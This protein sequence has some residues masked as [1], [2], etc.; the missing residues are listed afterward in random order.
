MA[1]MDRDEA[2]RRLREVVPR[3]DTTPFVLRHPAVEQ[4]L[5]AG[6]LGA[7]ITRLCADLGLNFPEPIPTPSHFAELDEITPTEA[8]SIADFL[9]AH[10]DGFERR[11]GQNILQPADGVETTMA[12]VRSHL[13]LVDRYLAAQRF[14]AT[15]A[16]SGAP[17]RLD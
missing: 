1:P 13:E 16:A 7:I 11:Q 14:F 9:R 12:D 17:A 4:P 5:S 15:V 10:F 3:E 8:A 6:D 2:R